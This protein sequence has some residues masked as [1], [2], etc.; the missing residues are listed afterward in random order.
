MTALILVAL[1]WGNCLSCPHMLLAATA[2]SCCHRT[3]TAGTS[4]QSQGL[5]HFLKAAPE[6]Q[7]PAIAVVAAL[8]PAIAASLPQ[9][10]L[11]APVE[12]EHAPPDLLS[13][14]SVFRI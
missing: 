3:K 2:H 13:L 12:V 4:C 5:Q 1:F 14:H 11:I 8:A 6:T 9:G 7:T 10:A